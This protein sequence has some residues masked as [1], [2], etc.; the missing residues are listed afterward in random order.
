MSRGLHRIVEIKPQWWMR[1]KEQLNSQGF[2]DFEAL[3]LRKSL[4]PR[5]QKPFETWM[6]AWMRWGIDG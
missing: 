1:F 6:R 3:C 2:E 5:T 4:E